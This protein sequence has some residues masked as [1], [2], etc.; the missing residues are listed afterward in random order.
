M[1]LV[2]FNRLASAR[3]TVDEALVKGLLSISGDRGIARR[4]LEKTLVLY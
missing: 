3:L 4:V 1:D 2:E